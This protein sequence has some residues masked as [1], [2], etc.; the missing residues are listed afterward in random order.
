M[1]RRVLIDEM[2]EALLTKVS[3]ANDISAAYRAFV[4]IAGNFVMTKST[5]CAFGFDGYYRGG[6]SVLT[7]QLG[8]LLPGRGRC[9]L[10]EE[11]KRLGRC[12][13]QAFL[14]M[15]KN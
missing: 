12:N 8:F 7:W 5:A 14:A 6:A 11:S 15:T 4:P 3:V 9:F 1:E 13:F 10:W 2:K